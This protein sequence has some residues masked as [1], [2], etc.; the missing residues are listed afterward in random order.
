[1][2]RLFSIALLSA[3]IGFAQTYDVVIRNGHIIDGTGSPW[4][5]GDIGIRAGRSPPSGDLEDA[6]GHGA[7]STRVAWWWPRDSSTCWANPS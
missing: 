5:A 4:Y 6:A 2:R 3:S 7:P 1:M